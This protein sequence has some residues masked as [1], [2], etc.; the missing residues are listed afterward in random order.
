[1]PR[2]EATRQV[3]AGI[4]Y[5]A[6]L[7]ACSPAARWQAGVPRAKPLLLLVAWLPHE[8]LST[9]FVKEGFLFKDA[10]NA[11]IPLLLFHFYLER[12][13]AMSSTLPFGMASISLRA[14][15]ANDR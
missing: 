9:E 8:E 14:S 5:E 10:E 13:W 3:G 1:M 15:F 12:R 4:S 2:A 7:P 11:K 6:L